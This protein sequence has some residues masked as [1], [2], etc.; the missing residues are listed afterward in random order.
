M[1][2]QHSSDTG[3]IAQAN[4]ALLDYG[5]L[6]S[7]DAPYSVAYPD[8]IE[9]VQ[10]LVVENQGLPIRVR[11]SGH[12]FNGCTLPRTGEL[13]IRT[14]NLDWYELGQGN[15]IRCGAGALVWDVKDL[16]DDYGYQIPV[17]NGGWAGPTLGGYLNAGGFGKGELS[18]EYGGLWENVL[19]V[20]FVDGLG[21][22]QRISREDNLFPWLFGAYG[23]F[24]IV[25][26]MTL[27][28]IADHPLAALTFPKGETGQIPKRQ[29]ED[30]KNNDTRQAPV[31]NI[32]FWFSILVT[33][34][35]QAD[36]WIAMDE[37]CQRHKDVVVP[38]GGWAGPVRNGEPIGYHYDIKFHQFNP[39]LLF[40]HNRDFIVMGVMSFLDVP[41]DKEGILQ[42][43]KDFIEL[44]E[45]GGFK[46]YL[47]AENIGRN[48]DYR[49]Y[50]G[51]TIYNQ[52]QA[53]KNRFDPNG[54][55][56]RSLI[57]D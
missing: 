49:R 5:K 47:Q 45:T 39:P 10:K 38:D 48:V 28:I 43:E 13:L 33:P 35:Q 34:E 54:L 26:E 15:T 57:F 30:P 37:F 24:G 1:S 4:E 41:S 3:S 25:V 8:S 55:I 32:L 40:P 51:D 19:E 56:N 9:A 29:A 31:E 2:D 16:V 46:L 52:F 7:S 36:A 50:Y 18:H 44:A 17:Y 12:T 6:Y 27:G 20:V 14:D 23:Q 53:L 22:L 21:N 11:G 42:I